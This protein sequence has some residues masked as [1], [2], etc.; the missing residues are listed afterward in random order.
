MNTDRKTNFK[1]EKK[2]KKKSTG[3]AHFFEI[4]LFPKFQPKKIMPNIFDRFKVISALLC[5]N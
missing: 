4:E 2:K 3:G 5:Y 1:E